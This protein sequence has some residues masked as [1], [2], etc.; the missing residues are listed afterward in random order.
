M[1]DERRAP[2]REPSMRRV[3]LSVAILSAGV[4]TYEIL[5]TRL[6]SIVQWHHFAYMIISLALL[7]FGASGTFLTFAGSRLAARFSRA[8]AVNAG[9]FALSSF[10]CFLIVQSLPLNLLEITWSADQFLWL[11]LAYVLL[12]LPFFFAANCI[13]LTFVRFPG[14]LATTYA[15]DL[16]GAGLGCGA[17]LWMLYVA[18][19]GAVLAPVA[20]AGVLAAVV[21]SVESRWLR[22]SASIAVLAAGA[23]LLH[24]LPLELRYSEYKGL[25]QAE[26]VSGAN[27]VA[28]LSSPL[29]LLSVV[30]NPAV[31]FRHAP[32]L[33]IVTPAPIPEQ[34]AIYTD[35]DSATMITRYDGDPETVAY[36]DRMSS[37]LPYHLD[38]IDS[39]LV[40]GAGAGSDVLQALYHGADRVVAVEMNAQLVEF[41][42]EEYPEFSGDLYRDD[43]VDV[44]IAEARDFVARDRDHYDLIQMTG[45]DAFGASASG[46][47][48]LNENYLYTV[49][50]L[51]VYLNRLEPDGL[52]AITRWIDLPP[53]D[54]IKL[55]ATAVEA[56]QASGIDDPAMHLAWVR[57]WNSITLVIKKAKLTRGQIDALHAFAESRQFDVAFYPDMSRNEANRYNILSGPQFFDAATALLGP[58]R[59]QFLSSYK[60]HVSPSSDDRPFHFHFFKWRHFPEMLALRA[61]GGMGLLELGYI[62]LIAALVQAAIVSVV[63]IVL[64]LLWMRRDTGASTGSA[65]NRSMLIGYFLSIGFAFL[66]IEIAFIQIFVRFLGHP[67]YSVTVVLA[68]FLLF[69]AAG[70]RLADVFRD[71][72]ADRS[73]LTAAI[74]VIVVICIAYV[75]LLP[76]ILEHFAGVGGVWRAVITVVL[77]APLA[78]AMGMPFPLGLRSLQDAPAV[79]VPWA[80]AINGCASVV[81][82]VLAV[83]L[84][85]HF[86]FTA[87]ILIAAA[88]YCFVAVIG[89]RAIPMLPMPS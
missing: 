32:G 36:M 67:V 66:F 5:L 14:V 71:A 61:R 10:G 20:A 43:R 82:A 19:P 21:S 26:R 4:L 64:P 59:E 3:F 88:L 75:M 65:W 58:G 52:I 44:R 37:A 35:A 11:A 56:L 53:R 22:W 46:L 81:S 63:L 69:A 6:L 51:Q 85:M 1:A 28:S 79:F 76:G 62:V 68:S 84:A 9:L 49:E 34:I 27:V 80:W 30:E 38:D 25:A 33:S 2:A 78:V 48:A 15:S 31:P 16:A 54:A 70:S 12:M 24:A 18:S 42:R 55:F 77:I 74:S 87:V 83:V 73:K 45:L 57:S 47:R 8:F 40:L 7:G 41:V 17:V 13:A 23:Y 39:V 86:G 29:G 89:R 50:A 72:V 60:F